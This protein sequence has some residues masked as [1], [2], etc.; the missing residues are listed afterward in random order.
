MAD[1]NLQAIPWRKDPGAEAESFNKGVASAYAPDRAVADLAQVQAQTAQTQAQA[2]NVALENQSKRNQLEAQARFA[3]ILDS[4]REAP[5]TGQDGKPVGQGQVNYS[6]LLANAQADGRVSAYVPD[7]VKNLLT[8]QASQ[9]KNQEDWQTLSNHT[10]GIAANAATQ[11]FRQGRFEEGTK[12]LNTAKQAAADNHLNL[13]PFSALPSTQDGQ[14]DGKAL[15]QSWL[16]DQAAR[17]A[18]SKAAAGPQGGGAA[19]VAP[20]ATNPLQAMDDREAAQAIAAST[21]QMGTYKATTERKGAEASLTGAAASMMNAKTGADQL[22]ANLELT[23][24]SPDAKT[25]DS[26]VSKNSRDALV[27]AGVSP[28]AI[29][30]KS[31]FEL[32]QVPEYR[33]TLEASPISVSEK[34]QA[35][36]DRNA[37][38]Q[39]RGQVSQ[40]RQAAENASR[41]GFVGATTVGNYVTKFGIQDPSVKALLGNI[42]AYNANVAQHPELGLS[43]IDQTDSAE[44]AKKKLDAADQ[45]LSRSIQTNNAVISSTT[46]KAAGELIDEQNKAPAKP[47]PGTPAVPTGPASGSSPI[48]AQA[49]TGTKPVPGSAAQPGGLTTPAGAKGSA[50][51]AVT[52]VFPDGK[53]K[54]TSDPGQIERARAAGLKE[55]SGGR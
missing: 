13:A 32:S 34:Q 10:Y 42:D 3:Q 24:Q 17:S 47:K 45:Y 29:A 40:L 14:V 55:V 15:A 43:Q 11:L 7:L 51:K 28:D 9:V 31:A 46:R 37:A 6:K 18:A 49:P 39:A 50:S 8:N 44:T 5:Q 1:F 26:A 12:L 35:F 27:R 2:Q 25:P 19:S 41:G 33:T 16:Q 21:A 52:F 30:G 36:K 23:F 54:T 22:K 38:T 20:V 48:P 4:S 53:L